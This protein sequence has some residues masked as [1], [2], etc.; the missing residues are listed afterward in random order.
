[1]E[2]ADEADPLRPR[3]LPP[4][5][6]FFLDVLHYSNR[7][8]GYRGTPAAAFPVTKS[9][10]GSRAW[11]G[12]G[13]VPLPAVENAA[14]VLPGVYVTATDSDRTRS[15]KR[16]KRDV[17]LL[18]IPPSIVSDMRRH[19]ESRHGHGGT[20]SLYSPLDGDDDAILVNRAVCEA[21]R[22]LTVAMA[23]GP[24]RPTI[25]GRLPVTGVTHDNE[26]LLMRERASKAYPAS[27]LPQCCYAADEE[28]SVANMACSVERLGAYKKALS[29]YP[30]PAELREFD[31]TGIPPPR[32]PCLLC[33]RRDLAIQAKLKAGD[34]D[35][36][37]N[38][39]RF[40]IVPPF[41]VRVNEPDGYRA[42][43]C[44]DP[45]IT[46]GARV[47]LPSGQLRVRYYP[48][49]QCMGVD[50][51]AITWHPEMMPSN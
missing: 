45:A 11:A 38:D 4:F 9:T 22:G 29:M 16:L 19:A 44:T 30:T 13:A 2:E 39:S 37:Q 51:T 10:R 33:I 42:D 12:A 36:E 5:V 20:T 14:E 41:T 23:P 49:T 46:G 17:A 35:P 47:P 34:P 31:K 24:A 15:T 28:C 21:V 43:A 27:K 18:E 50:Q 40:S 7:I 6:P 25:E 26:M 48:E 3:K 1:M 8:N 32:G